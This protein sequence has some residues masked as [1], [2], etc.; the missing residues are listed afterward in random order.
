MKQKTS[1]IN[2]FLSLVLILGSLLELWSVPALAESSGS[3]EYW[4]DPY[5]VYTYEELWNA[6]DYRGNAAGKK[7]IKLGADIDT[8]SYNSGYGLT[9][10]N[11]IKMH[12][13]QLYFDLNG[14]TLTIL[15]QAQGF[16]FAISAQG[17]LT[18][19]DSAG[20]GKILHKHTLDGEHG[21]VEMVGYYTLTLNDGVTLEVD[22]PVHSMTVNAAVWLRG[23]SYGIVN[24]AKLLFECSQEKMASAS[25]NVNRPSGILVQDDSKLAIYDGDF[26]RVSVSKTFQ[27]D[28]D[29]NPQVLINGGLFRH[30]MEIYAGEILDK[31]APRTLP[32]RING[33]EFRQADGATLDSNRERERPF[34]VLVDHAGYGKASF[35]NFTN[36]PGSKAFD[37]EV[38]EVMRE[39][40]RRLFSE[41]AIFMRDDAQ[42]LTNDPSKGNS[43]DKLIQVYNFY[44]YRARAWIADTENDGGLINIYPESIRVYGNQ[45][46]IKAEYNGEDALSGTPD[47]PVITDLSRS[48]EL[49]V[50]WKDVTD[51]LLTARD[52]STMMYYSPDISVAAQRI[53][54]RSNGDGTRSATVTLP[55]IP[56]G[57]E[58][59]PMFFQTLVVRGDENLIGAS[60]HNALWLKS[61]TTEIIT[62]LPFQLDSALTAGNTKGPTISGIGITP[63]NVTIEEQSRWS[64]LNDD[65][66]YVD[67]SANNP[68]PVATEC[69]TT[70]TLKAKSG[71]EFKIAAGENRPQAGLQFGNNFLHEAY[72][73]VSADGKTAK[74]EFRTVSTAEYTTLNIT[75]PNMTAGASV[76]FSAREL[77]GIPSGFTVNSISWDQEDGAGNSYMVREGYTFSKGYYYRC[78]IWLVPQ[79][80]VTVP[81]TVNATI[82]EKPAEYSGGYTE[83]FVLISEPLYIPDPRIGIEEITLFLDDEVQE[84]TADTEL[85]IAVAASGQYSKYFSAWYDSENQRVTSG[86]LIPGRTY[87][88]KV[89]YAPEKNYRFEVNGFTVRLYGGNA[90]PASYLKIDLNSVAISY[91]FTI[92]EKPYIAA[93][94][95]QGSYTVIFAGYE[96]GR[97]SYLKTSVQHF[98]FGENIIEIPDT[99]ELSSVDKIFIWNN[100]SSMQPACGKVDRS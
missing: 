77:L 14:K 23:G 2:R 45:F 6:M 22:A 19:G 48:R 49:T 83:G 10:D 99:V 1:N 73:N 66:E 40:T 81:T 52:Y 28:G 76:P 86:K 34:H 93:V 59:T 18:I 3:G 24:N 43:L 88:Y 90:L 44:D 69:S 9:P 11:A 7:F 26:T 20:G 95:Q 97:L 62:Y 38:Q 92:P 55:E 54:G 31:N 89:S 64:F 17:N 84:Y 72:M 80:G 94:D 91:P 51:E 16:R 57:Q 100:L 87:T 74:V 41:T 79:N 37:E 56:T 33:G 35:L 42:L 53:Y 46:D 25:H 50:T 36:D 58:Y 12:T 32:I 82:N 47:Q 15:S 96:N 60:V 30:S 39:V 27:E 65:W 68:I 70:L 71:H 13:Y 8:S 85:L 98:D 21:V 78:E 67:V 75:V 63:S 5:Y 61:Q 4:Y 29:K